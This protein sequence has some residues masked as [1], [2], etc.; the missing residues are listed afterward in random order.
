[1]TCRPPHIWVY[2]LLVLFA[3]EYGAKYTTKSMSSARTY[4]VASTELPID[5]WI[6]GLGGLSQMEFTQ[7]ACDESHSMD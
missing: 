2:F 1:M 6:Q 4:S 3:L 5:L 7:K